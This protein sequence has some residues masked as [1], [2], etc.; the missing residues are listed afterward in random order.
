MSRSYRRHPFCG[1]TTCTSEKEDKQMAQRAHRRSIHQRL[2]AARALP[3]VPAGEAGEAG[4]DVGERLPHWKEY[5]D[6]WAWGKDGRAR[7]DPA[8]H[9]ALMRK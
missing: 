9:P 6:P 7:F 8:R 5:S 1:I 4:E 3:R 2:V